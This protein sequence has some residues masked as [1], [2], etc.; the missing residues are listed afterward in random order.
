MAENKST[1]ERG[2]KPDILTPALPYV[3]PYA[4]F[5]VLTA[6]ADT[7]PDWQSLLYIVKVFAVAGALWYYRKAYTELKF[8]VSVVTLAAVVIGVLVIVAWVGLDP[9]YPQTGAEWQQL[10]SGERVFE[11]VEKAE[12]QF[13]P[14]EEG[15][16]V[17]P[18]MAII[19]RLIGAAL[20][21]PIFE[22]LFVRSWLIRL[23]IKEDFRAVPV[24]AFS[25]LSF[26]A[27]VLLFGA[28]HHEWLAGII[29]GVAFNLLLY[30]KKDL[31]QCIIAHA[32]AN[33]AL[34]IWVLT[35]GAWLFW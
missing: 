12:G 7:V 8:S 32:V 2:G 15:Q 21:V 4:L 28:T 6:L 10:M 27:T 19:F 23:L 11:H 35:Q 34:G 26:I 24:G 18:L 29:C 25:W 16:A 22:E 30:W 1:G 17:P 5:L 20:I 33:L 13:N 14:F 9:Y 31:L 3:V